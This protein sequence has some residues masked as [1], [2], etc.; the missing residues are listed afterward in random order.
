MVV[1]QA[2]HL[3]HG[4][5]IEGFEPFGLGQALLD[6]ECIHALEVGEDDEL[7]HRGVVAHVAEQGFVGLSPLP[8]CDAKERDIEQ[9]SL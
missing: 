7:L 3:L 8:S 6:E 9:I 4:L 5:G 1:E 2:A